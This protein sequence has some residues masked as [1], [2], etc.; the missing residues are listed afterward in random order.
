MN[1]D[2]LDSTVPS[3]RIAL[4]AMFSGSVVALGGGS[5]GAKT[6]KK[7]RCPNPCPD[8]IACPC[9]DGGPCFYLPYPAGPSPDT[10]LPCAEACASRRGVNSTTPS[11]PGEGLAAVRVRGGPNQSFCPLV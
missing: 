9:N 8:R 1:A 7:K 4:A 3:R 6:R 5:V 2:C 10:T 11:Y